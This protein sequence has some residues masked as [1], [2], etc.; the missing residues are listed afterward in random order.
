MAI[1]INKDDSLDKLTKEQKKEE[2]AKCKASP[3]YF[4]NKY[5]RVGHP[6]K[7]VIP[8][9]LFE[10]QE[11]LLS[12]FRKNR[13]NLYVKS[14][15]IGIS[16]LVACYSLW[17]S[18]F[19]KQQSIL[20]LA[21]KRDVAKNLLKKVKLAYEQLPRLFRNHA[22]ISDNNSTTF[23]LS[24]GS[25]IK[26]VGTT[27]D[28]VRSEALSLMIIDEAAFIDDMD[29][30]W[31]AAQPALSA[32]GKCIALSSPNG[33][34]DWFH[35]QF[36][37]SQDGNGIFYCRELMWDLHPERDEQWEKDARKALIT[38]EKFDQEYRC[39]FLASGRTVI[40]AAI[41]KE[42]T[43]GTEMP[44]STVGYENCLW[45]WEKFQSNRQYLITVDVCKGDGADYSVAEVWK[46]GNKLEQVAEFKAKIPTD[47]FGDELLEICH[48]YGDPLT[49]VESNSYGTA[50]LNILKKAKYK[51]IFYSRKK[52][53]NFEKYDPFKD[54]SR[55][56]DF[57]MGI[58]TAEKS[59][60]IIIDKLEET[61][62]QS[63]IVIKSSRLLRELKTFIWTE[64]RK[65]KASGKNNDDAVMAT[66]FGCWIFET[67]LDRGEAKTDGYIDLMKFMC[68]SN[69][70]FSTDRDLVNKDYHRNKNYYSLDDFSMSLIQK[71]RYLK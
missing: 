3:A 12:E 44:A 65:A 25:E 54:Y 20:I 50:V 39:S 68:V 36:M 23:K 40:P 8:F 21:T 11:E 18:V 59:R 43:K 35:E 10:F 52:W 66:S 51:H 27:K 19:Y 41:L 62:R 17:M 15:Q 5:C 38:P 31:T 60:D 7:G 1:L 61:I 69:A 16:T 48:L 67:V 58:Y 24:T 56:G 22:A 63:R 14:R 53:E 71:K 45:I 6:V 70:T 49:A 47:E 26:C 29:E 2:F 42:I 13:Y 32:G 30:I 34:G 28:A 55:D 37:N 64:S 4:I 46:L 33:E 9:S 57:T